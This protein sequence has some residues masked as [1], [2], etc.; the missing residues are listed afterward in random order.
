MRVVSLCPSNTDIVCALGLGHLLVGVD[1]SS[2]KDPELAQALPGQGRGV[3][4]VGTDLQIDI[5]AITA[6]KPD[7]VL[8]SLS[9]PGMER[10][11]EQLQAARLPYLV[12]DGHT[13]AGVQRGIRQVA[14]ALG[15]T[16]A[17]EALVASFAEA[18]EDVRA[19]SREARRRLE[20]AGREQDLPRRAAWEWWPKPIIVAG[21]SSWIQDFFEILGVE[22]AFADI[23]QESRPVEN[24]EVLRRAPDTLCASW[25]GSAERRMSLARI[26]RRAGWQA[27]P[28]WQ[29]RRIFLVPERL[30]GR[31]GPGLARGLRELY[32]LFYGDRAAAMERLAA[33][34]RLAPDATV[35]PQV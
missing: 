32:E 7:L 24:E 4:D 16:A 29:T 14:E 34:A 22:N 13:L 15:A 30:V 33:A 21:R 10:N 23:E 31:P 2:L 1:R 26:G 3:A 27:L 18:L 28:A 20:Q 25:C 5:A 11:I 12:V 17:G 35:W 19:R 8:A 9:V 6:L